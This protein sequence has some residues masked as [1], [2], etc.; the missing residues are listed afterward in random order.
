MGYKWSWIHYLWP[1][2]AAITLKS[3][4]L[5][6]SQCCAK[7]F[8]SGGG[9]HLKSTLI[10]VQA[11]TVMQHITAAAI[12]R[13]TWVDTA[14][15][16][17]TIRGA[18]QAASGWQGTRGFMVDILT[19]DNIN[20]LLL[21]DYDI[22]YRR[23]QWDVWRWDVTLYK[24]SWAFWCSS[25]QQQNANVTMQ[26]S[27]PHNKCCVTANSMV[28]TAVCP[29][30]LMTRSGLY[31]SAYWWNI[32]SLQLSIDTEDGL[33]PECLSFPRIIKCEENIIKY[34]FWVR[35]SVIV[36]NSQIQTKT[37]TQ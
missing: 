9:A 33:G 36:I 11:C 7:Q 26:L 34:H 25:V 22:P 3:E 20:T 1:P 27:I 29:S 10:N 23:T 31:F 12:Q 21:M 19:F 4:A 6:T 35:M 2:S 24:L 28:S 18:E 17:E 8:S 32:I 16:E 15:Q 13:E 14:Q 37:L 5:C 30:N